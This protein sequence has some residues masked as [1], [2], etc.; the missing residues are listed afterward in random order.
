MLDKINIRSIIDGHIHTF[1]D[2]SDFKF[3]GDNNIKIPNISIKE[4]IIS[5]CL[6]I[7]FVLLLLYLNPIVSGNLLTIISTTF[8]IFT[9]VLLSL[10][11]L[12]HD[13]YLKN[14]IREKNE[15]ESVSKL[16]DAKKQKL[17]IR[18]NKIIRKVI[19]ETVYNISFLIVVSANI[20]LA[21][22]LLAFLSV[23]PAAPYFILC[24]G[25]IGDIASIISVFIAF[26]YH[27]GSIIISGISY[28]LICIFVL[29]LFMVLKRV[30]KLFELIMKFEKN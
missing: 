14:E 10:L 20:L 24:D 2:G 25:I 9:A 8:S 16:E 6:P 23:D 15:V 12:I 17:V 22:L 11:L 4:V 30:V 18:R 3:D 28:Y 21:I 27:Y 5:F 7:L 19:Q 13:M 26:F 29:T 1:Y